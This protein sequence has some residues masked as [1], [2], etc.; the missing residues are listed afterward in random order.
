MGT[1]NSFGELLESTQNQPYEE[2]LILVI[3]PKDGSR[4]EE[5]DRDVA[6]ARYEEGYEITEVHRI[7][8]SSPSSYTSVLHYVTLEWHEE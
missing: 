7:V 6:L 4:F 2:Q 8:S 3:D 1:F 5:T